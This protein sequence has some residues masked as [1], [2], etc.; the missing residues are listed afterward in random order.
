MVDMTLVHIIDDD[1]SIRRTMEKL[2]TSV[3]MC[4]RSY[5]T[6]Q[7]FLDRED[8]AALEGECLVLDVRMPGMGGL[9]FQAMLAA[10]GEALPVI[11]LTGHADVP[12]SVRAMKAGA[13]DFLTKPFREQ[14]LLEAAI[15]ALALDRQRRTF[16]R[17]TARLRSLY[18]TLSPRERQVMRLVSA[19]KL[20]KQ[21]AG[22]L[23]LSEITVKV[24]RSGAMRKMQARTLPDLVRM[25]AALG[26]HHM[27]RGTIVPLSATDAAAAA[28][29]IRA[30]HERSGVRLAG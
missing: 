27:D 23:D 12:M 17:E 21:V 9:D 25:A 4:S 22:D 29:A 19:G 14:E 1:P 13:F 20:N 16:A 15:A 6:A 24:Y 10:S 7:A 8:R 18:E 3:G 28:I 26:L 2:F 30:G 5:A 11:M